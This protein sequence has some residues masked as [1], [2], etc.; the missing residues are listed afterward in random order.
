MI[1]VPLNRLTRQ[2]GEVSKCVGT[3]TSKNNVLDCR[4]VK[5]HHLQLHRE[6]KFVQLPM[7]RA[8]AVSPEFLPFLIE[9]P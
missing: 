9:C 8:A 7:G 2:T 4:V 3:L 1:A 5:L 6:Q